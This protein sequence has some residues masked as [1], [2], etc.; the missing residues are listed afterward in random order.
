MFSLPSDRPKAFADR[1]A[2][3][4][5]NVRREP[6]K[7][8]ARLR[9]PNAN[10]RSLATTSAREADSTMSVPTKWTC[11]NQW[12]WPFLAVAENGQERPFLLHTFFEGWVIIP[13]AISRV[14]AAFALCGLNA[15][16]GHLTD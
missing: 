14:S 6:S 7:E 8:S 10:G 4:T 1:T 2:G 9:D 16:P 3:R 15:H 11:R 13:G 12:Q 5:T